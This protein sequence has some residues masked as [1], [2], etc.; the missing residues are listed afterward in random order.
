MSWWRHVSLKQVNVWSQLII[1]HAHYYGYTHIRLMIGEEQHRTRNR[2]LILRTYIITNTE[3]PCWLL[4]RELRA[5][6]L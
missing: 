6:L 2:Q 4:S 1:I 5:D 3:R